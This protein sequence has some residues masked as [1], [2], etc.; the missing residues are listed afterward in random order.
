MWKTIIPSNELK[1]RQVV[2]RKSYVGA[3]LSQTNLFFY[4]S[5][6]IRIF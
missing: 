4:T 2:L 6:G 5:A 1:E 3:N